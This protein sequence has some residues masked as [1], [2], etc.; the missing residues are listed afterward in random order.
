TDGPHSARHLA[1]R[2]SAWHALVRAHARPAADRAEP[3]GYL[4]SARRQR[5][6]NRSRRRP[7]PPGRSATAPTPRRDSRVRAPPTPARAPRLRALRQDAAD[8]ATHPRSNARDPAAP[9]GLA[10]RHR[11]LVPTRTLGTRSRS[12]SLPL[13][14][15]RATGWPWLARLLS[16]RPPT[17]LTDDQV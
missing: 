16:L 7:T 13:G 8:C 2:R 5:P 17:M 14:C 12:P 10:A 3:R 1:H 6:A 4:H 9:R 11:R 15:D